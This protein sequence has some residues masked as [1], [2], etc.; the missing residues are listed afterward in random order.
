MPSDRSAGRDV[1]FYDV[2]DP[3]KPLGGLILTNGITN[4]NF[5]S[6]L[7][8]LLICQEPL[9]LRD[10]AGIPIEKDDHPLQPGRYYIKGKP[11]LFRYR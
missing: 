11:S 4:Q 8:I 6:M 1:H 9:S 2:K 10:E 7:E 3:T 5:Y